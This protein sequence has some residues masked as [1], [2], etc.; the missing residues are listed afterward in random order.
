MA[1]EAQNRVQE[2]VNKLL[3]DLDQSCLRKMQVI[4]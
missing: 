3:S 2:H 4:N 1:E